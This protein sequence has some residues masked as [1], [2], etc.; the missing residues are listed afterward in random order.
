MRRRHTEGETADLFAAADGN[1]EQVAAVGKTD[2][3]KRG[4]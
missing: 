2:G 1:A 3:T 4:R